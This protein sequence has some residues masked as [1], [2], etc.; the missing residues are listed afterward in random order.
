MPTLGMV[1]RSMKPASDGGTN[2]E[3]VIYCDE[4]S[5]SKSDDWKA[6]YVEGKHFTTGLTKL[7]YSW[8]SSFLSEDWLAGFEAG[9]AWQKRQEARA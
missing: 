8:F 4:N 6:G 7:D 1:A 9:Q 2:M 3:T 5:P